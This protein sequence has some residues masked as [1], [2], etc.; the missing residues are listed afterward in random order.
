MEQRRWASFIIFHENYD[1]KSLTN[2]IGLIKLSAPVRFNRY[3]RPI[4]LP[5][6]ATAGRDFIQGPPEGTICTTVGWGATIE[7]GSDR[8]YYYNEFFFR[9]HFV[10]NINSQQRLITTFKKLIKKSLHLN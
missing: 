10:L 6:E 1:K 9:D 7:H 4:C 5:S 2:D 3:V 8:K